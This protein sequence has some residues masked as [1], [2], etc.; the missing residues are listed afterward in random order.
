MCVLCD[1]D[2]LGRVG[3]ASQVA[4]VIEPTVYR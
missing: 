3:T 2:V 4:C 1:I